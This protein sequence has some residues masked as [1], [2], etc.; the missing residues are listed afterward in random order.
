MT[1]SIFDS[2]GNL[3]DGFTDRSAAFDCV[4]G[5]AQAKREAASE[6]YL[7]A[8]DSDGNIVGETVNASSVS[9]PA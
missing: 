4:A 8:Q 5:I 7:I 1:F 3:V 2:A 9:V 6:V